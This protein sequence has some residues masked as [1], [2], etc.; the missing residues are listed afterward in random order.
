MAELIPDEKSCGVVVFRKAQ[1][2][3]RIYLLLHYP[4][5]HIDFPKGHVEPGE[6]NNE[7]LTAHRELTEETGIKDLKFMDGF[8]HLIHYTYNK[9]GT[10]SFKQV[11]F[12]LGETTEEKVTLSHEHKGYFWLPFDQS[13]DKLTHDNAKNLLSLAEKFLSQKDL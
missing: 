9:K 10:P 12:F 13:L 7:H 4:G 1:N 2:G 5:G 3:E 11:V 6:E 8:R